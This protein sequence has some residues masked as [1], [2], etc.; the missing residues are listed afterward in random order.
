[1]TGLRFSQELLTLAELETAENDVVGAGRAEA[2]SAALVGLSKLGDP[3]KA[4]VHIGL[5][6]RLG[7]R[8]VHDLGEAEEL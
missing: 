8:V 2:A 7:E 4:V 1:V 3:A 6:A 5:L